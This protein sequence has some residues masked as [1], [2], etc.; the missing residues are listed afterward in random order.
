MREFIKV[1]I[2]NSIKPLDELAKEV[3]YWDF[4]YPDLTPDDSNFRGYTTAS[5][6]VSIEGNSILFE[7]QDYYDRIPLKVANSGTK[8][9]LYKRLTFLADGVIEEKYYTKTCKNHFAKIPLN[10]T[11]SSVVH[12]DFR[13]NALERQALLHGF[14]PLSMDD[15]LY[16]YTED[17]RVHFYGSWEGD[18]IFSA[19]LIEIADGV[20][21]FENARI[22]K[23]YADT[24]NKTKYDD[25]ILFFAKTHAKLFA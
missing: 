19:D 21:G 2:S 12:L 20:W 6:V 4:R 22:H 16:V 7:T 15:K 8:V 23:D 1:T 3:K 5:V 9:S 11:N 10:D 14:S 24:P 13:F 18:E 17:N 25:A